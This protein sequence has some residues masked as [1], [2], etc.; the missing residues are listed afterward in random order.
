MILFSDA[1]DSEMPDDY[2]QTLKE[3]RDAGVTVS[4]IGLGTETDK[5]AALLREVAELGG[6]RMFF[7][8]DAFGVP[9]LFAQEAMM[10]SR[11]SFSGEKLEVKGTA[12]WAELATGGMTWL[13]SVDGFN[14][15]VARQGAT[16]AL[17]AA[18]G[19]EDPLVAFW[20]HG[21]GRTAAVGFPVAGEFS[22]AQRSWSGLSGMVGAL[23]RWTAAGDHPPGVE[24]G[25][26]LRG[27]V[28]EVE[29]F[30]GSEHAETIA[31]GP[32][33]LRLSDVKGEVREGEWQRMTP[34][35]FRSRIALKA[36]DVANGVVRAG[37]WTLPFGPVLVPAA[38]EWVR[39]VG[40]V[41]DV[42]MLV[43]ATGGRERVDLSGCWE[44]PVRARR[45]QPLRGWLLAVWVALV[46]AEAFWTRVLGRSE[47]TGGAVISGD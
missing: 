32:P 37:G 10:V 14:A 24:V 36:G 9:A 17:R 25:V 6:G 29:F 39:D 30:Y 18:D 16:V 44:R 38:A 21:V 13:G 7:Q 47:T 27:N 20:Q 43:Q 11:P 34:G 41:G 22:E 46:V 23:A 28:L 42:R 12:G 31:K 35:H 2:R 45:E 3:A 33:I 40:V 1:A 4:V 26:R 8:S 5:D 19:H 15:T